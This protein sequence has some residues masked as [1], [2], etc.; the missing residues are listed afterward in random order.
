M[1]AAD[2]RLRSK[3]K[4]RGDYWIIGLSWYDSSGK[5]KQTNISTGL[6]IIGNK[7]KAEAKEREIYKEYERQLLSE[8]TEADKILFCDWLKQWL[9]YVEGKVSEST[10]YGYRAVVERHIIPFFEDKGTTLSGLT[11]KKIEAYYDF[12]QKTFNVSANTIRHE[13]SYIH[14]ALKYAV[15]EGMISSNPADNVRLPKV[16]RHRANIYSEEQLKAF[17]SAIT[18]TALEPA[19]LL[20]AWFGMRRGEII[21]LRWD[22]ID[23]TSKTLYVRGTVKTQGKDGYKVYYVPSA[24]NES[25]IRSFPMT[26]AQVDYFTRLKEYQKH[27]QYIKGYH[28]EWDDFVCTYMDGRLISPDTLTRTV[29]K[30][31]EAC[32]LPRLK[33]HEF[34]HTN[35]SLMVQNGVSIFEAS[36]WAGHKTANT[37][38]DFYAQY[39]NRSKEKI[40]A[41]LA[42]LLA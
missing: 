30:L 19:I 13:N 36:K 31:C 4:Q 21:G 27:R 42:S 35:I 10:F 26:D 24:K 28:H 6:K 8:T 15:I 9:T 5:R 34:R 17:L 16:Q 18:G 29:P 33:L 41:L 12:R 23:F 11:S 14:A 39:D 7:Y 3:L 32:G 38:S 20:A 40:S 22:C 37:T 2:L 25:S 1:T